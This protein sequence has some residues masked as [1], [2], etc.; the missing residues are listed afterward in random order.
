MLS[1]SLT[2]LSRNRGQ[3]EMGGKYICELRCSVVP[4]RSALRSVCTGG[5]AGKADS[6]KCH[7]GR[8]E[9]G[10]AADLG[11]TTGR[12]TGIPR[13]IRDAIVD[14][15]WRM[16]MSIQPGNEINDMIES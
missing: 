4:C 2:N 5:C 7:R 12:T 11:R 9:T 15:R 3:P 14:E 1:S 6:C 8:L 10:R 13:D 16:C